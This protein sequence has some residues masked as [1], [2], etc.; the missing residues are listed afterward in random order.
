M[1]LFKLSQV[2]KYLAFTAMLSQDGNR[3]MADNGCIVGEAGEINFDG[4][5]DCG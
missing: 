1:F 5:S 2:I 3:C 4:R